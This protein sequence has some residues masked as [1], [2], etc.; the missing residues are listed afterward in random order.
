MV[1][2][3]Q[4]NA[5]RQMAKT[6]F[7]I[8]NARRTRT[9]RPAR[10]LGKLHQRSYGGLQSARDWNDRNCEI[11]GRQSLERRAKEKEDFY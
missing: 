7:E 6:N 8:E 11:S 4:E 9:G 2:S 5:Q 1:W 3:H 10:G